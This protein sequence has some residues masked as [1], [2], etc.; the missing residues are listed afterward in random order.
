MDLDE[1]VHWW[2]TRERSDLEWLL[3]AVGPDADT[4]DDRVGRLRALREVGR[5]LRRTGRRRQACRAA[6]EAGAAALAACD[7]T[8][9]S[10]ED[11][12]GATRLARAAGDAARA[13]VA[14]CTGATADALLRPLLGTT[15]VDV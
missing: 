6:H 9:I 10:S 1:F 11:R 14:G 12:D 5:T 3:D 7:A 13:I 15:L 8:G 4:A 2:E